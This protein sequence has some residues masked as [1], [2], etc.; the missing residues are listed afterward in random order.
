MFVISNRSSVAWRPT[1][2]Y[3]SVMEAKQRET[4]GSESFSLWQFPP[5][6]QKV[7]ETKTSL[8]SSEEWTLCVEG[9]ARLEEPPRC[10][11][12][13]ASAALCT[14]RGLFLTLGCFCCNIHHTNTWSCA[15]VVI[16]IL[17]GSVWILQGLQLTHFHYRLNQLVYKMSQNGKVKCFVLFTVIDD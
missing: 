13:L 1:S 12:T 4:W 17:R 11:L 2:A 16:L 8:S 3:H 7:G 9:S 10:G 14:P 6:T 15:L 5:R